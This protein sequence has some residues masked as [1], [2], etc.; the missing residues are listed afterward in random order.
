MFPRIFGATAL[1][2]ITTAAPCQTPAE[3]FAE[4]HKRLN[5]ASD[6]AGFALNDTPEA[7]SALRDQ[8]SALADFVIDLRRTDPTIAPSAIDHSLCLLT[9]QPYPPEAI[10]VSIEDQCK[11]RPNLRSS[12]LQL[13]PNL[14]LIAAQ[15]DEIGTVFVIGQSP[16]QSHQAVLWSIADAAPQPHDPH[17][18]IQAWRLDRAQSSCRDARSSHNPFSCGPLYASVG[19]LPP[20]AGHRP[21]FYVD[22]GYAQGA[23]AT[24]GAQL[25]IWRWDGDRA[26]LQW[27]DEHDEMIDD[28][29][30]TTVSWSG[31][32]TFTYKRDFHT[33]FDCGSCDSHP[34][35]HLIQ[36]QPTGVL[37]LG[38]RSLTP[39]LDLLDTLFWRIAHRK[40]TGA[41]AAPHVVRTLHP[42]L[43]ET[44]A[45]SRKI[46]PGWDSLGMIDDLS[47]RINPTGADVCLQADSV[48]DTFHFTMR[49]T[50]N[51]GYFVSSLRVMSAAPECTQ[52]SNFAPDPPAPVTPR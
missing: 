6:V 47:V 9:A 34:T 49:R 20:D 15:T 44:F 17:D 3:R 41:I 45:G 26:S 22:A 11:S 23:G 46:E 37:D 35:R 14:L 21:R 30:P 29:D 38:D 18:L 48:G 2:L 5:A 32:L 27:I 40:S 10:Q 1:I 50:L 4:A 28:D 13:N 12:V 24:I 31:L 19:L 39:E 42:L 8:W 33:L 36:L 43:R 51:R 7:V 16:S 25:S 52:K